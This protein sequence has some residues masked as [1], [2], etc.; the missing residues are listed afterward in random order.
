[1]I[2]DSILCLTCCLIRSTGPDCARTVAKVPKKA[3]QGCQTWLHGTN[4]CR[5]VTP[6]PTKTRWATSIGVTV[7]SLS[8]IQIP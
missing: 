6:N 7:T 5:N 3:L 1:M 8:A 4:S 2:P